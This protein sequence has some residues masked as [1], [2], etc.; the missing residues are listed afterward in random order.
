MKK[1]TSGVVSVETNNVFACTSIKCQTNDARDPQDLE[2]LT[3]SHVFLAQLVMVEHLM[4]V[5]VRFVV[6]RNEQNG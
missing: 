1:S 2:A 4:P 5:V 6:C 3:P